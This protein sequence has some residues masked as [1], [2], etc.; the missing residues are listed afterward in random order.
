VWQVHFSHVIQLPTLDMAIS[1][2]SMKTLLAIVVHAQSDEDR[3]HWMMLLCADAYF[4][5]SQA[6]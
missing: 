1:E 3:K 4:L 6:R 5:T 2:E